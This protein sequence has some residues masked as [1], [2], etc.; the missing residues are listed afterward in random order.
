MSHLLVQDFVLELQSGDAE[1]EVCEAGGS[2]EWASAIV[3]IPAGAL[4]GCYTIEVID[5]IP[6]GTET[7]YT[8]HSVV[9]VEINIPPAALPLS[10]PIVVTIPYDTNE[11]EPGDFAA[12]RAVIY[13]APTADDLRN[14]T[15]VKI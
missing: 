14:G 1:Q 8:E 4:D 6:V 7:L 9:L 3:D 15:N 12:G 10:K 13:H 11:V 5:N 2:L